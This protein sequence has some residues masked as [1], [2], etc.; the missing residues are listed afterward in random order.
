MNNICDFPQFTPY[1]LNFQENRVMSYILG[2]ICYVY[3]ILSLIHRRIISSQKFKSAGIYYSSYY[4][5]MLNN[6][7][8][9]WKLCSA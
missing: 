8:D 3:Y 5:A 4:V 1:E 9:M 6:V 2:G 7:N